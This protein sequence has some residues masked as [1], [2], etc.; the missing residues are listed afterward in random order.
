[1]REDTAVNFS[2][3][4]FG[5]KAHARGASKLDDIQ[6]AAFI[7]VDG[8]LRRSVSKSENCE[9]RLVI[10]LARREMLNPLTRDAVEVVGAFMSISGSTRKKQHTYRSLFV[11]GISSL[12]ENQG[13]AL[14]T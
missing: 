10:D 2:E 7:Y 5:S 9:L 1:M 4:E 3:S 8:A 14:R 11:N 12:H 6:E 13:R